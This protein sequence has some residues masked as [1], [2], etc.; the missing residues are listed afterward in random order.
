MIN[1]GETNQLQ[2]LI[3]SRRSVRS[4]LPKAVPKEQVIRI[5]ESATWAPSAHNRQPWR[6]V[7]LQSKETRTQ[8]VETM[9]ILFR[10]DLLADGTPEVE[11]ERTINRATQRI[12]NAPVTVLLCLDTSLG[13][14]YSDQRRQN[15]EFLMG[16][17]GV[18]M[19]GSTLLLAAHALGLGGVWMCAPLFA[20]E[21]VKTV[22]DLPQEW[23]PQGLILLGYT[24]NYPQLR[25][26][27]LV[28]E[29]T[30]FV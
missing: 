25:P 13:D 6:F 27:R 5:L 14:V 8:F 4:F 18:A 30:R 28:D 10:Q 23:E 7:V 3:R 2:D 22:L 17:Q 1:S 21:I 16:V 11:I 26:R 9:S 19:A 24:T 15:A 20:A 12:M 29:V